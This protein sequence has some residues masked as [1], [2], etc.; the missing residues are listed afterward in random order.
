MVRFAFAYPFYGI[1]TSPIPSRSNTP[2]I[3][4]LSGRIFNPLSTQNP[5]LRAEIWGP[6]STGAV[7]SIPSTTTLVSFICP[8]RCTKGSWLRF[9]DSFTSLPVFISV[10]GSPS[11]CSA[12]QGAGWRCL[13]PPP[14][15]HSKGYVDIHELNASSLKSKTFYHL[16]V[17]SL[18]IGSPFSLTLSFTS[19][20]L[21]SFDC[22][23]AK[24]Y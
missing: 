19:F 7:I 1:V 5:S 18:T 24:G 3:K 23:N 14:T 10:P 16:V 11:P 4:F 20:V 21:P 17:T 9:P 15:S 12:S 22:P 2:F 8:N 13:L 6:V